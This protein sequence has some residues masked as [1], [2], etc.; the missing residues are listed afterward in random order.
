MSSY[1]VICWSNDERQVQLEGLGY[2]T[3]YDG[4]YVIVAGCLYVVGASNAHRI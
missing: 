3:V 2:L 1:K 4:E